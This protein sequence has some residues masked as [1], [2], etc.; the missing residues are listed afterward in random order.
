MDELQDLMHQLITGGFET[1][2][3]A[4][5]TGMWLLLRHPDQLELLRARAR[6]DEE[7]HRGDVALRQPGAGPVAHDDVP[8]RGRR[9]V[10]PG[11]VPR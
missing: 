9:R 6:A 11:R 2:T 8:R 5:A 4:L 1:T 3:G 7:L 10:H